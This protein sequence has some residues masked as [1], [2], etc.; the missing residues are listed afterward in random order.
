V[1]STGVEYLDKR[2][3]SVEDFLLLWIM[4]QHGR[5]VLCHVDD[6][7]RIGM[8]C[9]RLLFLLSNGVT[10]DDI[11][12]CGNIWPTQQPSKDRYTSSSLDPE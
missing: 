2:T 7:Q 1:Y 5:F 9:T 12:C 10:V 4:L 11:K 6:S 3:K 8:M